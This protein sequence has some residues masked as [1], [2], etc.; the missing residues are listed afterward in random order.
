MII[1]FC[2]ENNLSSQAR[3]VLSKQVIDQL[4]AQIN[5][6]MLYYINKS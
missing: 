3:R 5:Q 4:D 2:K 1:E 6:G